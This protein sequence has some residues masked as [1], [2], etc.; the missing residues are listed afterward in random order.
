MKHGDKFNAIERRVDEQYDTPDTI[1][2]ALTIRTIDGNG[3][4]TD[5]GGARN[6]P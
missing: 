3:K 2:S 5:R 4:L 6:L 1:L